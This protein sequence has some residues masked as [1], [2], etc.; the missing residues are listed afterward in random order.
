MSCQFQSN[1]FE[2]TVPLLSVEECQTAIAQLSEIPGEGKRNFL[3]TPWCTSLARMLVSHP[4]LEPLLPAS[5]VA[6][7]CTLFEKSA[8]RN[9]LVALHQDLSIPVASRID[10]PAVRGWSE[11]EGILY[12][13]PPTAVLANIVAVRLQLDESSLDSGV[14]RVVPRSHLYGHLNHAEAKHLRD[15]MG[16]I[17]C[18]VPRG[19]ALILS[20]LLLHASSKLTQP[21][22]RRVL[23]FLFAPPKLPFGLRWSNTV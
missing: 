14:L 12:A 13:Q 5:A 15:K 22:V 9:W 19:A 3:L 17:V 10:H 7:Q 18:P 8:E 21:Y 23:H 4:V 6:V 1:G 20:P 11:K 2:V 16:E